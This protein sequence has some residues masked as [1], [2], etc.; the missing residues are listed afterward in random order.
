M[1]TVDAFRADAF[2]M[3]S[4]TAAMNRLPYMPSLLRTLGLYQEVPIRT[5][6]AHVEEKLGKLALI[7]TAARGTIKD[8]RQADR[9][10]VVN[11]NVPHVPYF[12]TVRA[13][14]IQN[15]RAFGSETELES[16]SMYVNDQLQGM[17]NDHDATQE[18]HRV[19]AL[20][21]LI[22]DADGGTIYDLYAAFGITQTEVDWTTGVAGAVPAMCAQVTRTIS[23]ALGNTPFG[24]IF[25]LCGNTYFDQVTIDA[26]VK[27]AY[28]RW[29]Q[30]EYLRMSQLGPEWYNVAMN[31]FEYQG[32]YFYNYRG[33]LGAA[34]AG[35][36]P[37]IA[38]VEAYYTPT[39]VAGMFQEIIAPADF[40]ETVNTRGQRYY[41]KQQPVDFDKG[42]ELHT[43][44][45]ILAMNTT[46]GG[47]VKSTVTVA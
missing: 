33:G 18:F 23:D 40:M 13:D 4:L 45:N 12:Q 30:G 19:G 35:I 39:N 42:V 21:G 22:L 27:A 15:I 8:A 32:I 28:D 1:A 41:A 38:D 29:R 11:F 44:S 3:A 31:G 14:D 24:Q 47:V 5:T 25:A 7:N 16:M 34:A 17:K 9:R 6:I 10:R 36:N 26:D 37:M 20:K 46:P 2:S 43:Q